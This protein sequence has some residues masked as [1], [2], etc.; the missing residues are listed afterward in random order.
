MPFVLFHILLGKMSAS[1]R[2]ILCTLASVRKESTAMSKERA[3]HVQAQYPVGLINLV[4]HPEKE[5]M[6]NLIK[7]YTG[8]EIGDDHDEGR[9]ASN[10]S[11]PAPVAADPRGEEDGGGDGDR[12][13]EGSER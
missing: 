9:G 8:L 11:S 6:G 5:L 10:V 2:D 3:R 7:Q 1:D 13:D 4:N 12:E